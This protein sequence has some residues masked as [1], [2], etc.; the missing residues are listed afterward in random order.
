M[1]YLLQ[2]YEWTNKSEP[3]NDTIMQHLLQ[4]HEWTNKKLEAQVSQQSQF[5]WFSGFWQ[6]DFQGFNQS[7]HI[8]GPDSHV[9]FPIDTKNT[10]I[11]EDHPMNIYGKYGWYLFSGFK[12]LNVK[13]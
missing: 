8:I 7:E 13:S 1:Q 12:E 5:N 4:I 6:E 2:T 10:N 9:E 11:V 3:T